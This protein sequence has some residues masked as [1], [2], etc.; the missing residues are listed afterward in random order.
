MRYKPDYLA[1]GAFFKT[2]T[3]S[4]KFDANPSLIKKLKKYLKFQLL[5]LGYQLK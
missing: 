1:F 3:K 2:K 4:V 5:G